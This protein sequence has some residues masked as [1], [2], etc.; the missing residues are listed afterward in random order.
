[1]QTYARRL[2]L[3]MSPRVFLR[4]ALQIFKRVG[5]RRGGEGGVIG[6]CMQLTFKSPTSIKTD[7]A[8]EMAATVI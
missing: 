4:F 5:M 1:M 8:M 7:T 2:V 3:P 6:T